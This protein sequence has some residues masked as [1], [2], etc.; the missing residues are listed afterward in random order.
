M[1]EGENLAGLALAITFHLDLTMITLEK[2]K[3]LAI[4]P[5][6]VYGSQICHSQKFVKLNNCHLN[7]YST[8]ACV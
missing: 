1:K 7:N 6:Q 5:R 2:E 4:Y 3:Y 8:N